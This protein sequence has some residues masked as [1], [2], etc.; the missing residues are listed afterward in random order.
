MN[1]KIGELP[2]DAAE[3][4]R[5]AAATPDPHRRIAALDRASRY[6]REKYPHLHKE[7]SNRNYYL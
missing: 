3:K 1:L 2:A 5:Q 7:Q 6:A 4:L